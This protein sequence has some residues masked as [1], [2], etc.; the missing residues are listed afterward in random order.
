MPLTRLLTIFCLSLAS[1]SQGQPVRID[2]S[3]NDSGYTAATSYPGYKLVWADEFNGTALLTND[4]TWE[5]GDGC[6]ALCG[7]GNNELEYYT[8]P[9]D[10]VSFQDGKMIIEARK[11]TMGGKQYT[12]ARLKT[13]GKRTFKFGRIDIRAILPKT[14]GIWPA[15][16]LMPQDNVYGTWPKSGELD[17]M[18]QIGSQPGKILGTIHYG[19]GPGSTYISR[20][21]SLPEGDFNQKFH[22]F[23]LEWTE[24]QIKWILD[25]HVWSTIGKN[26][27]GNNNWPFNEQ[28][29]LIV[30]L[31]VGGGL[32]GNPDASTV[33]PQKLI[34]DYIRVY[35]Q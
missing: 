7:W 24:D 23:S 33:L 27:I 10:N 35:Q 29:Y 2:Q 6:P 11:E 3:I 28:F 31:A 13:Q 30:N 22:V 20:N 19:P 4:W 15:F 5:T 21:Y 12:S 26:D 1:C 25:D 32:P 14:Q 34:V 8:A 18:E 9:P 17:M 16:W